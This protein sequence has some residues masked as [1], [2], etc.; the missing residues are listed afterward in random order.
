MGSYLMRNIDETWWRR[1]KVKAAQES[2]SV[3]SMVERLLTDWLN[4]YVPVATV[5]ES[6][7]LIQQ[8]STAQLADPYAVA[9]RAVR[10]ADAALPRRG[11]YKRAAG[12][13]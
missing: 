8:E 10:E 13:K 7:P 2:T 11:H 9:P 5:D 3:K 12:K 4:G 6:A 1:V